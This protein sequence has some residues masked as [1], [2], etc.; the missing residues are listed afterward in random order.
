MSPLLFVGI[1]LHLYSSETMLLF[2]NFKILNLSIRFSRPCW[3][4]PPLAS[5]LFQGCIFIMISGLIREGN[6]RTDFAGWLKT[7]A[8]RAWTDGL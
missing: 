3:L 5:S 6:P 4:S 8:R 1:F 2:L 7:G